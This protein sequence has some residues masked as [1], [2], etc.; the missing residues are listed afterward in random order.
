MLKEKKKKL[1]TTKS[2]TNPYECGKPN[3]K[4]VI[5]ALR[6]GK[7]KFAE[8]PPNDSLSLPPPLHP[9]IKENNRFFAARGLLNDISLFNDFE[10]AGATSLPFIFY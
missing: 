3:R 8:F 6:K 2:I 10:N 5:H 7:K 1:S 4:I 9:R